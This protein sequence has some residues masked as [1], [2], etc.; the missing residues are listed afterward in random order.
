MPNV[1]TLYIGSTKRPL[2]KR[3]AELVQF[4]RGRNV[5]HWGGRYLWQVECSCHFQVAWLVKQNPAR[6]EREM[7]D[8]FKHH[9]HHLPFANLRGGP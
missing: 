2:K 3:I 9:F 5:G 7:L 1:Q 8:E 4:S 6:A